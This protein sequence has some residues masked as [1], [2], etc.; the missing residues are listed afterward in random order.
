M[1]PVSVKGNRTPFGKETGKGNGMIRFGCQCGKQYTAK[2]ELA[3]RKTSCKNCGAQVTIP[4]KGP[5][6]SNAAAPAVS[7]QN[8]PSVVTETATVVAP[9]KAPVE[10]RPRHLKWVL[11]GAGSLLLVVGLGLYVRH[12]IRQDEI[13]AAHRRNVSMYENYLADAKEAIG[14]KDIPGAVAKLQA[15]LS[16]PEDVTKT[17]AAL[18]LKEAQIVQSPPAPVLQTLSDAE[19]QALCTRKALPPSRTLTYEPLNSIYIERLFTGKDDEKNRRK[20]IADEAERAAKATEEK[21]AKEEAERIDREAKAEAERKRK[22]AEEEVRRKAEAEREESDRKAAEKAL[23]EAERAR[24]ARRVVG[25]LAH[26]KTF[27]AKIGG[28]WFIDTTLLPEGLWDKYKDVEGELLTAMKGVQKAESDFDFKTYTNSDF[29]TQN[30]MN[31]AQAQRRLAAFRPYEKAATRF[32]DWMGGLP[33]KA[34]E[35]SASGQDGFYT[36]EPLPLGSYEVVAFAVTKTDYGLFVAYWHLTHNLE[37]KAGSTLILNNEN[38]TL[39]VFAG[40]K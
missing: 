38:S 6:A 28:I 12:T 8:Q 18:L 26:S 35:L 39:G 1:L 15:A 11:V 17:E 13:A 5:D 27:P 22:T 32:S 20:V 2:D 31:L 16:L 3:G 19:F 21:L 4:T 34:Y 30:R 9:S 10:Q 33:P 40:N 37:E 23:R 7:G 36:T 14:K 29:M 24:K 25:V